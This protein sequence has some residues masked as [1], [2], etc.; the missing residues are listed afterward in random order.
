L[1][2]FLAFPVELR[3]INAWKGILNALSIHYRDRI[4][5]AN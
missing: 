2:P 1:A 3:R 5:A 4:Q